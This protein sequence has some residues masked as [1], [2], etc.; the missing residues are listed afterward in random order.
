M[1]GDHFDSVAAM[2]L[3]RHGPVQPLRLLTSFLAELS[4]D[5][6]ALPSP[7]APTDPMNC[8]CS[9]PSCSMA[10]CRPV[11]T[12]TLS[13]PLF[14]KLQELLDSPEHFDAVKEALDKLQAQFDQQLEEFL[15]KSRTLPAEGNTTQTSRLAGILM[16]KHWE[17]VEDELRRLPAFAG[18]AV[19]LE[20]QRQ[21]G[22]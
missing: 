9:S 11:F 22:L 6:H 17:M 8:R 1:L 20:L 14:A 4:A 18:K 7:G 3:R 19:A 5:A 16:Q 10:I 21:V 15:K 12:A 2:L 13:G